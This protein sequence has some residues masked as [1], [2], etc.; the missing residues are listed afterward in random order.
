[1]DRN[2]HNDQPHPDDPRVREVLR[3]LDDGAASIPP[4]VEDRVAELAREEFQV[5]MGSVDEKLIV[6]LEDGRVSQMGT[7][8]EL[9][10]QGGLYRELVDLQTE[11]STV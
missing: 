2:S 7:H 6:V 4:E 9:M 5:T 1:M 8:D 10:V 3:P 11:A